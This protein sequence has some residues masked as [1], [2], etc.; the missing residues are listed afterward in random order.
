MEN[1]KNCRCKHGFLK[2]SKPIKAK[3]ARGKQISFY[4][5]FSFKIYLENCPR[6]ISARSSS[7][8]NIT[9]PKQPSLTK[10]T[11][12]SSESKIK[13]YKQDSDLKT[14]KNVRFK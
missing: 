1:S 5:L 2:T 9:I 3:C 7:T 12:S 4:F 10:K 11:S 14:N 13:T 8:T 6:N